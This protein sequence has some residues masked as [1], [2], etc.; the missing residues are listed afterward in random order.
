MDDNK[1]IQ[2]DL[3]DMLQYCRDI[4]DSLNSNSLVVVLRKQNERFD[5]AL[6]II[7]DLLP[8]A[9]NVMEQ[10]IPEVGIRAATMF[11]IALWSRL[12]QGGSV[13][14]MTKDDWKDVI[15]LVYE[16]AANIDPKDYSIL[17]FDLYRSSIAFAIEPMRLNAS[18]SVISRLEEIVCL[19]DG[20]KQDLE[21]GTMPEA[22]L[23]E[24]NLWLSLEAVFLVMTDRMN[25]RL[26][27]E[28]RRELAEAVGALAFQKFR[29][30]IYEKELAAVNECLEYQNKLDQKLAERVNAYIDALNEELDEFDALVEVAFNTT[31]F[32]AAFRGSAD[33][34][35]KLGAEEILRT[36]KDVDEY[37]LA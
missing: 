36:R 28:E 27:P 8:A 31:D 29:Y 10:D 18:P 5:K 3:K 23:I 24:E 19:M 4:V 25:Y 34:A 30:S 12:R 35:K 21:S 15:G 14:E 9:E 26:I 13:A 16:Q 33:L 1:Y 37:F 2:F 32:Q 17:V 11:L 6:N 20:Y 22:K 7:E